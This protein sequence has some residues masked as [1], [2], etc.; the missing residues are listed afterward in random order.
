MAAVQVR[1][2]ELLVAR[3]R[4]GVQDQHVRPDLA[5]S[6]GD[7]LASHVVAGEARCSE[8]RPVQHAVLT[9]GQC[10]ELGVRGEGLGASCHRASVRLAVPSGPGP[11]R[12]AVDSS[13]HDVD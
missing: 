3:Q 1:E 5:P 6:L 10:G 8:L 7:E 9:P 13:G 4:A 2:P 11:T 12:Q